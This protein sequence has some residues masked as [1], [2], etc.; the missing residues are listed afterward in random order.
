MKAKSRIQT[1]D[2]AILEICGDGLHQVEAGLE[3][4]VLQQVI[5]NNSIS[6]PVILL[7][8]LVGCQA[9]QTASCNDN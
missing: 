8:C 1:K 5:R 4:T 3:I 2:K 6:R 7:S 9:D